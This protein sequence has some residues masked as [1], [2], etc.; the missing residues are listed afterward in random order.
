MAKIHTDKKVRQGKMDY[1][2]YNNIWCG[3]TGYVSNGKL[4]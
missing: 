3:G 4:A 2:L 1:F